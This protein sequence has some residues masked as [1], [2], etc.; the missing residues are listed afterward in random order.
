MKAYLLIM[1]MLF[2]YI[3]SDCFEASSSLK[4]YKDCTE[5]VLNYLELLAGGKYCCYAYGY[6][7]NKD[8]RKCIPIT[9]NQ[10][11]NM[12][13]TINF[14]QK[15]YAFNIKGF[16]CKSSYIQIG[17]LGLLFLLF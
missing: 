14:Y 16:D 7:G 1:A 3:K 2:I 13:D 6:D 8:V 15:L 11:E 17:L 5:R 9:L 10:Y 4:R 12:E